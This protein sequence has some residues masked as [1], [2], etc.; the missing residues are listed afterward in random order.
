MLPTRTKTRVRANRLRY[1][2]LLAS[3]D[4]RSG[5]PGDRYRGVEPDRM[6]VIAVSRRVADRPPGLAEGCEG[7]ASAGREVLDRP[8]VGMFSSLHH[9][10]LKLL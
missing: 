1:L 3:A 9:H 10:R 5:E 8:G 4:L 2:R 7:A 6:L